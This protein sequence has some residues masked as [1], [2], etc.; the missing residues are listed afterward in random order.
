MKI[1]L[2]LGGN[3]LLAKGQKGTV[4]EQ[5]GNVGKTCESISRIVEQGHE[6]V[7]THGNGPQ[8]G[9]L[10]IQQELSKEEVAAMPMDVC[11]AMTQGQLG[12]LIQSELEKVSHRTVATLITQIVVDKEDPGFAKP[13]KPVG[14]F[15]EEKVSEDMVL[16]SGRGWRKVVPSPIP[17]EVVEIEAIKSLLNA[18]IIVIAAGGGGI[19]VFRNGE[20]LSGIAAVIDKDRASALIAK[21]IKANLLVVATSIDKVYLDFGKERQRG[22]GRISVS[23]ARKLVGEGHFAE[24]SMKPKVES[25]IDFVENGGWRAVICALDDIEEAIEG[26]AGTVIE[27]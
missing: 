6:L 18:G 8:I 12:Y 25:C 9:N 23:E 4:D 1:V 24:G 22:L 7:V 27:A 20:K 13:S 17:L 14:P 11:D 5:R 15:Y 16:D 3:A 10:L 21:E 2:A 26:K 19:P